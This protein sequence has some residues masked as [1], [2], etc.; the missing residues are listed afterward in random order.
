MKKIVWMTGLL[1]TPMMANA[2]V[3]VK[4]AWVRPSNGKNSALF[5]TFENTGPADRLVAAEVGDGSCHH[6]ELHTHIHDNGVMKMREVKTMD[7]P[8]NGQAVLKPGEDHIMLMNLT[9]EL[10][11]GALVPV[12]LTFENGQKEELLVPVTSEPVKHDCDCE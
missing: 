7:V 12:T 10:K 5:C 6:M 9:G 8:E 2:T 11:E 3:V 4:D 1:L